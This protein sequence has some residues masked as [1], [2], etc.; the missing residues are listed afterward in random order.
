MNMIKNT[1]I[2][3]VSTLIGFLACEAAIRAMNDVPLRTFDN[4][5]TN[6]IYLLRANVMAVYD[7]ELGWR[8]KSN[9]NE[10]GTNHLG[11]MQTFTTDEYGNRMPRNEYRAL[12]KGSIV[13]VG[14]S[15]TVGSEVSDDESWPALLEE[16]LGR[17]I[18]NA[19]GGG[20]GTDQIILS[21]ERMLEIADPQLTIVSFLWQD[22]F[23]S[24]HQIYAGGHKP[25]FLIENGDLVRYNDP[26]P[27]DSVQPRKPDL[28]RTTLG[29]SYLF[30]YFVKRLGYSA[31]ASGHDLMYVRA[32]PANSGVQISCMLLQRFSK[33]I[34][35]AGRQMVF[36]VQFASTDFEQ[37]FPDHRAQNL[38]DCATEMGI[39][40]VNPWP[41]MKEIYQRNRQEFDD[42]FVLQRDGVSRGHMSAAGNMLMAE[43]LYELILSE[44]IEIK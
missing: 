10:R 22:L 12:P 4:F 19:S 30:T 31:W 32:S 3:I 43:L 42:L 38:V 13:A 40:T 24:E 33:K 1:S 20:W 26:V 15:F 44:G 21:G 39:P 5:I 34:Q 36:I 41:I 11:D 6:P 17:P 9:A 14:D 29:H 25:Y 28:V 2:V 16:K 23:R 37:N 8:V 7:S 27:E 18:V 35:N